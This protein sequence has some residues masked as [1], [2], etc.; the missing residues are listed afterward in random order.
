MKKKVAAASCQRLGRQKCGAL[1]VPMPSC[2][3]CEQFLYLI[4]TQ[5]VGG[6]S[7]AASAS[8][9][10]G[11]ISG[12]SRPSRSRAGGAPLRHNWGRLSDLS[13]QWTGM[14]SGS[15]SH[16]SWPLAGHCVPSGIYLR[17]TTAPAPPQNPCGWR[18]ISAL[19]SS[20]ATNSL[21]PHAMCLYSPVGRL[22]GPD[23]FSR[24]AERG[25]SR[26][27]ALKPGPAPL[28][29]LGLVLPR[30]AVVEMR[31]CRHNGPNAIA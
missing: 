8:V 28:L 12:R 26:A 24:T 14:P 18:V 20:P 7:A 11:A 13:G 29:A 25:E 2:S 19:S 27:G 22:S 1:E 23:T 5:A 10:P 4:K 21:H 6:G 16:R 15:K 31:E 9:C 3:I 17:L 30:S